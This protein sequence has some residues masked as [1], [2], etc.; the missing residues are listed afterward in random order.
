MSVRIAYMSE[1]HVQDL[2]NGPAKFAKLSIP[3]AIQPREGEKMSEAQKHD[4]QAY[5]AGWSSGVIDKD[6]VGPCIKAGQTKDGQDR[7]VRPVL[8]TD[9]IKMTSPNAD[10]SGY[11][12]KYLTPS[13]FKAESDFRNLRAGDKNR[14]AEFAA[15]LEAG[16]ALTSPNANAPKSRQKP[17]TAEVVAKSKDGQSISLGEGSAWSISPESAANKIA[18]QPHFKSRLAGKMPSEDMPKKEDFQDAADYKK[19]VTKAKQSFV[20][21]FDIETQNVA[22]VPYLAESK[23]KEAQKQAEAPAPEVEAR[24]SAAPAV[25]DLDDALGLEEEMDI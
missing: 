15:V 1:K 5:F 20:K 8:V 7:F 13:R 14:D 9:A 25:A 4:S 18:A 21:D 2:P 6:A 19:A 10:K 23:T 11:D 16:E 17:Y 3:P 22:E 24:E 12:V